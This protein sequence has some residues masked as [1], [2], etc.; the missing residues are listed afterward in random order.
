MNIHKLTLKKRQ[1][2]QFYQGPKQEMKITN[3]GEK[4][5]VK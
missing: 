1:S 3:E 4:K 2:E 5:K